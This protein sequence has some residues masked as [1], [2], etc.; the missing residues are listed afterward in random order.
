MRTG[1]GSSLLALLLAAG[2][3]RGAVAQVP[4]VVPVPA[5]AASGATAA[6]GATQRAQAAGGPVAP[7]P[8]AMLLQALPVVPVGVP[9][10]PP[11]VPQALS[12][13]AGAGRLVGLPSA[14][15][16]VL[17]ADPRIARVQPASPTS[18][19][20]MG[21]SGGR[22]NIVATA[23]NGTPIAEYAVTVRPVR[24]AQV[25]PGMGIAPAEPKPERAGPI[26]AGIEAALRQIL[27]QADTVR[28]RDA[29]NDVVISGAVRTAGE[30]QRI[31]SI[32]QGFAGEGRKVRNG[33]EV[34]SSLQVN[35]RVRVAEISRQ[36]TRDL[37][38]NWQAI[39]QVGEFALGL[40][41][42]VSAGRVF[43]TLTSGGAL[44]NGTVGPG[45]LGL[46][47]SGR[48][49]DV[50]AIVDALAA[51]QLVTILAEPNLT[52]QSGETASFL[53]G[54]EF[55][56]PVSA[57]VTGQVSIE[58]KQFGVSLSFVPTVLS[59]ERISLRVRPEVSELS[60]NGAISVPLSSGTV[61]I[62]ALA[63]RRAETTLELGSGQSFAIGGLL[64]RSTTQVAQ[65][66]AALQD[67]PVLGPLFRSDSFRRNESEL[68]ILVTPYLVRPVSSPG[69]LQ[70][71]VDGFRPATDLERV[72]RGRQ[73]AAG[74]P[75][76]PRLTLDAGFMV[77]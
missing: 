18:L 10:A 2:L 42:G 73:I 14:A 44:N 1:K 54:G 70:T 49:Y 19:F 25:G 26:A 9:Q 16:T 12:L 4:Q 39:G 11:V 5:A 43:S 62:P 75:V 56:V 64:Q 20:I 61:T 3:G 29:G 13:D 58:F 36:V 69:V 65:G 27:G 51:D 47:L 38:F 52:A 6:P 66:I 55:P 76:P 21:V 31:L 28:V 24:E 41:S 22:T 50:N 15:A 33:L 40:Q 67:V 68:V 17:A 60:S 48:R 7:A 46:G 34:L 37:G 77:E 63:V 23:E 32:A 59:P 72:L 45:R 57:N 30:A 35:V 74:A 8:G 71:P 53:A